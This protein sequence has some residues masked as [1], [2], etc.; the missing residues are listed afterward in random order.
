MR[1]PAARHA[2]HSNPTPK[3]PAK[4]KREAPETRPIPLDLESLKKVAGGTGDSTT[5]PH[6]GW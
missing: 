2:A 3:L 1:R 4:V 6:K 5:A